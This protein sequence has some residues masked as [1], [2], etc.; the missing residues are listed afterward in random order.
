MSCET[1]AKVSR[2]RSTRFSPSRKRITRPRGSRWYSVP[3]PCTSSVARRIPVVRRLIDAG[4]SSPNREC[5]SSAR[6]G[7]RPA[8]PGRG[9]V[10]PHQPD[11]A[12]KDLLEELVA[13]RL[14]RAFRAADDEDGVP[15]LDELLQ[16]VAQVHAV[17]ERPV[18]R[19]QQPQ[20]V[21]VPD[22]RDHR[23]GRDGVELVDARL[24]SR[25]VRDRGVEQR[26]EQPV[27]VEL[28]GQLEPVDEHR[29]GTAAQEAG[30][31][32]GA[33]DERPDLGLVRVALREQPRE[34]LASVGVPAPG[35]DPAHLSR[36][37]RRRGGASARR[38]G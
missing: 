35:V 31:D 37:G 19:S 36:P 12:G 8:R 25:S 2:A 27:L 18:A 26:P 4:A 17:D 5:S 21:P 29:G 6:S 10:D 13:E 33:L 22:R 9:E 16:A 23:L 11:V 34:P 32:P 30:G 1:K 24:E 3:N 7:R 15:L 14:P 28:L 38:R 20:L